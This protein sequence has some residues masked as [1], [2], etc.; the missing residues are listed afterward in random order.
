MARMAAHR[1]GG[2]GGR[3]EGSGEQSPLAWRNIIS[4]HH[5]HHLASR[6]AA[7][8][9]SLGSSRHHGR[10][11]R[12]SMHGGA[13]QNISRRPALISTDVAGTRRAHIVAYHRGAKYRASVSLARIS[14]QSRNGAHQTRAYK[15][16][17]AW[18]RNVST[19][20]WHHRRPS[21]NRA[22]SAACQRH[23]RHQQ[24]RWQ[25][26]ITRGRVKRAPPSTVA[27]ARNRRNAHQQ[28]GRGI[29]GQLGNIAAL[30]PRI[31]GRRRRKSKHR[32]GVASS[33]ASSMQAAANINTSARGDLRRSDIGLMRLKK[34]RRSRRRRIKAKMA[35][36]ASGSIIA[37]A[38]RRGGGN[39]IKH[40]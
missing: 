17:A 23:R 8:M 19:G 5:Q 32:I 14:Y 16:S 10:R 28:L 40:S 38:W 21:R 37:Q 12:R 29:G 13:A 1:A 3:R 4:K 22:R 7:S 11:Q 33:A 2:K 6:Q 26:C 39:I 25:R 31:G 27:A 30:A 9:A 35:R 20:G 34:L 18:R 36:A 24:W 15:A